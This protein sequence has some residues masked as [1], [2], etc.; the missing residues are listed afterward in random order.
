MAACN[1]TNVCQQ[2]YDTLPSTRN[3]DRSID[4][5]LASPDIFPHIR[6]AGLVPKDIGFSTSD[7]QDLFLDLHP[8]VL[9]TKN[10]LFQPPP[11]RKL[12]ISNA[13]KV[14]WYTL[15]VLEKVD[16]HNIPNHIQQFNDD[17][18]LFGFNY[19]CRDKL[20]KIDHQM[21]QIMLRAEQYLSPDSIPFPFTVQLLEQ[22]N[23]VHLTK[24][25]HNMKKDGKIHEI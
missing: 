8:K 20:E 4:H 7:H 23:S 6:A 25:L 24:H 9:D 11:T 12:R 19:N 2:R 16:D 3:N 5:I 22:I 17:I 13:P 14:E 18:E 15:Q 10:I 1:L 21:T